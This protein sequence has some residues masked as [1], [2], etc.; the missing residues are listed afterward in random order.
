MIIDKFVIKNKHTLSDQLVPTS[1][2]QTYYPQNDNVC[3]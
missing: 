1:L 2:I 3:C